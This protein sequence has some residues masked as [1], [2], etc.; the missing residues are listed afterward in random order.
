MKKETKYMDIDILKVMQ[1]IVDNYVKHYQSDF[2]ID[3]KSIKE[4]AMKPE[5]TDRFFI[6][7]CRECGTGLWKEKNIFIKES[8]EYSSF[9][10]Y[11]EQTENSIQAFVV[12]VAGLDG[13]TVTGNLYCLSYPEYYEHVCRTAIPAR[14]IILT[15]ERGQ[16]T[17]PPTVHIST[18]PNKELGKFISFQF[19]PKSSR[20]LESVLI[21]EKRNRN[22]F[23]ED[24][25][26]LGYEIYECPVSPTENGR[27]YAA[28]PLKEQAENIVREAKG[29]GEQLFMKAICSDGKKRY[30]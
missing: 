12:E 25:E 8:H 23:K 11:A 4:A 14:G 5:R 30:C 1:T 20:Q 15:Y 26:V 6:W 2:D 13:G 17:M 3:T 16:R 28:T 24:Y 10:Y 9:T 22:K 29:R 19:I 18:K 27:Y 7:M 21:A